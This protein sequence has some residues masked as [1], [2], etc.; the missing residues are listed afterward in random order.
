MNANHFISAPVFLLGILLTFC[1]STAGLGQGNLQFDGLVD[2]Q[3]MNALLG[4]P[5]ILQLMNGVVITDSQILGLLK[6]RNSSSI[7]FVQYL[8]GKRKPKRRAADIYRLLIG[9]K[10]YKL[11]YHGPTG[12]YYMIDVK[13]SEADA[14]ARLGGLDRELRD[15]QTPDEMRDAVG[16]QKALFNEGIKKMGSPPV[17]TFESDFALMV[18]DFPEPAAREFLK[19]IDQMTVYMNSLFGLPAGANVWVGK[20]TLAVFGQRPLFTSF[21]S[22]ALDNPNFGTATT[23]YHAN[24]KRFLIVC[25]PS[26]LGEPL[27]KSF[28]WSIAGGYVDR[29]RSSVRFPEWIRVGVR[30]LVP[31]IVFPDPR[32]DSTTRKTVSNE[33]SRGKSLSGILTATEI[34]E[35]RRHLAKALIAY[36]IKHNA[37]SFSQFFEDVKLGHTWEDA[38]RNNYGATPEQFA[39]AFGKSVGISGVTP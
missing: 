18:T 31:I 4:Q 20:V 3:Q 16:V 32:N 19:Y 13:Q 1:L 2:D 24:S 6:D 34:G 39:A 25:N 12:G 35:D 22:I 30:E 23:I 26:K 5:A 27:A 38:L 11:R 33:L 14:V 17:Q 21:E 8:D 28:C 9:G 29:Y 7:Q 36:L 10:P 37:Q 15:P